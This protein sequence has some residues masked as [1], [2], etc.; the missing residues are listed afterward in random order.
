MRLGHAIIIATFIVIMTAQTNHTAEA[1]PQTQKIIGIQISQT[2]LKSQSCL[3]YSDIIYLDRTNKKISGEFVKSGDDIKRKCTTV[4]NSI[5]YYSTMAPKNLT[6]IVDPCFQDATFIPMIIIQPRLDTYL[7]PDHMQVK[8]IG[9]STERKPTQVSIKTSHTRW[10]DSRCDEAVITAK[11][12]KRVLIDTINYL[13]HDCSLDH[14]KIK[15]T[16]EELRPITKHDISTSYKSKDA[17]W[18]A[19]IKSKCLQSRNACTDLKQPTRG[20]L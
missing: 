13:S 11:D 10:V 7:L 14:T 9:N 4:K 2:C 12:W 18:Q 16:A 1:A 6:L 5:S 15:T 3:D 20:G 17:K 8:E 19:E